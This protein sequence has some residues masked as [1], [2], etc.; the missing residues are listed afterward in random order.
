VRRGATGYAVPGY[1]AVVLD[2]AGTVCKAGE[3][4]RLAVK[5]PTGC[6]YL[7]D[8]R[9]AQYVQAGWNLTGDAGF[10]DGAGYFFQQASTA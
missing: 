6:L 7:A 3:A 10:M 1:R 8:E 2:G 5:G 9:Q 4:G